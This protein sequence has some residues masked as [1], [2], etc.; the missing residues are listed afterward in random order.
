M[1]YEISENVKKKKTKE[2]NVTQL[3]QIH[4]WKLNTESS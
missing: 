2:E 1:Y 3:F 4:E